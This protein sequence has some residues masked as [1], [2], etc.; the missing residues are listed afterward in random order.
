MARAM[1][2]FSWMGFHSNDLIGHDERKWQ[3]QSTCVVAATTKKEALELAD[4]TPGRA[5]GSNFGETWNAETVAVALAHP[6]RVLTQPLDTR[7]RWWFEDTKEP[8]PITRAVRVTVEGHE[9]TMAVT[10]SPD[11]GEHHVV[12]RRGGKTLYEFEGSPARGDA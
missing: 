3:R 10:L 9:Y 8:L 2:V 12:V 6:G 4:L 1:K 11:D 5:S 7:D